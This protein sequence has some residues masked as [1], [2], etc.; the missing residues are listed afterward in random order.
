MAINSKAAVE[1]EYANKR[2]ALLAYTDAQIDAELDSLVKFADKLRELVILL[3]A[4]EALNGQPVNTNTVNKISEAADFIGNSPASIRNQ[5]KLVK[6][7]LADP[8]PVTP[9]PIG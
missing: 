1:N 4:K 9:A 6:E 3:K 5:F 7:L 2:T 8:A